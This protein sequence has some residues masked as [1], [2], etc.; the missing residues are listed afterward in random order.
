MSATV[1]Q[2]I[3]L[4]FV[5]IQLKSSRVW[6]VRLPNTPSRSTAVVDMLTYN[7]ESTPLSRS[8]ADQGLKIRIKKDIRVRTR[9]IYALEHLLAN[10][11]SDNECP[12]P[13][14]EVEKVDRRD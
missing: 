11:D 6:K 4:P 1:D 9:P 8:L 2:Y 7:P 14:D 5:Y 12:S 13:S 10:Q 3:L